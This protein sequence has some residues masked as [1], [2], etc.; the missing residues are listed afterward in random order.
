MSSRSSL[1][2]IQRSL[3]TNGEYDIIFKNN[4]FILTKNNIEKQVLLECNAKNLNRVQQ[5]VGTTTI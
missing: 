4:K 2:L 3:D 1:D 5:L